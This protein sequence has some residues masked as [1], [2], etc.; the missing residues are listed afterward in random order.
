MFT[1]DQRGLDIMDYLLPQ[2]CSVEQGGVAQRSSWP[3]QVRP[4]GRAV[5]ALIT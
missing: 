5:S 1:R 2:P 3:Q 4:L